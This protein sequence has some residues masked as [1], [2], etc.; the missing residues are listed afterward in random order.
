[1]KRLLPQDVVHLA[2]ASK[3][4]YAL[5]TDEYVWQLMITR[6]FGIECVPREGSKIRSADAYRELCCGNVQMVVP[7]TEFAITWGND[8]SY[9]ITMQDPLSICGSVR[10]LKNVCWVE[11]SYQIKGVR[12]GMY[13]PVCHMKIGGDE[14]SAY[15]LN[16]VRFRAEVDD[17][18]SKYEPFASCETKLADALSWN[19]RGWFY[20]EMPAINV[21]V[22]YSSDE[23]FKVKFQFFNHENDWKSGLYLDF[24]KLQK[25][26]DLNSEQVLKF[27]RSSSSVDTANLTKEEPSAS[28]AAH[29]SGITRILANVLNWF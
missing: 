8:S 10:V 23:F 11:G 1:V 21:G 19:K 18:E 27:A 13:R 17:S 14:A 4:M 6:R 2:L 20:Y 15:G 29:V 28:T 9:W 26:E 12:R 24:V 16:N 22:G 7:A 25:V 5:C 3:A